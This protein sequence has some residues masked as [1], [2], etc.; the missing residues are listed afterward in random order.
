MPKEFSSVAA[1]KMKG[2]VQLCWE[3]PTYKTGGSA[4]LQ[5]SPGCLPAISISSYPRKLLH[6][7]PGDL[8]EKADLLRKELSHEGQQLSAHKKKSCPLPTKILYPF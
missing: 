8:H 3:N 7:C 6:F 1:A 5:P 2:G 4:S